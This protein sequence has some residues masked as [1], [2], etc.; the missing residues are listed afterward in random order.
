MVRL[1]ES[2]QVLMSEGKL[3][4]L[5]Q[6]FQLL[7]TGLRKAFFLLLQGHFDI[8]TGT[9]CDHKVQPLLFRSLV[10]G[11]DHFDLLAVI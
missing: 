1:L 9:G 7:L 11:G 2:F 4:L 3:M 6:S 8:G 10:A 5:E